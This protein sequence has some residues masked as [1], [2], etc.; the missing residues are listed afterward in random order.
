MLKRLLKRLAPA[1][2]VRAYHRGLAA[3]ASV[4]YGRPSSKMI[5]VGVTGTNGKSTT[6]NMIAAV[7]EGAGFRVGLAT[8]CNFRIAGREWLNDTK[9]TMLGRFRL[10][11]LLRDMVAAGCDYAV[12][13]TSS[14]GIA[15]SRHAGIDYDVAVFTNLTPEHI[16]SHGGFEHY[17]AAKLKLFAKTASGKRKTLGG[18]TIPKTLVANLASPYAAE[19][20][21]FK[22]NKK[23]GFLA[24]LKGDSAPKLTEWPLAVVKAL[25]IELAPE[26]PRFTVRDVSFEL[27][28]P[29]M[30]NVENALAAISVGLSQAIDLAV[31][32]RA[33]AGIESV[34]GRQERIDAGQDFTAMVDYSHEPASFA[35]LYEIIDAMPKRRVIHVIGSAGGG[36]DKSR[37]TVLG[38][39][40]AKHA[41]LVVVT[42]EDP[43]DEDPQEII[44]AVAHGARKA[45]K[46]DGVDLFVVPDRRDGL[47]KAVNLAEK[48]DLVIATGKGAEQWICV[49]GGKKIPWDERTEMRR[50]IAR[51][52]G[53]D[54]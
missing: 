13:E 20:L 33:L 7:L 44:D 23:Y 6:S 48:G 21:A 40:A 22:A 26:G 47:E 16:E 37:R 9:M 49:A 1:G 25:G 43:Y 8:T 28:M 14:E 15:Q 41:D 19:F 31:M 10:Q 45:G 42:N 36:R 3:L 29:G 39:L 35:R 12:I 4:R 32:S 50:A 38:E 2:A 11:K 54:L 30:I 52:P 34:P 46:K 27:K 17:K 51:K 53:K 5:V 24:E 18:K